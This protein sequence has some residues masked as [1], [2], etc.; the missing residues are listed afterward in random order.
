MI[1]FYFIFLN[2]GMIYFKISAFVWRTSKLY[3]IAVVIFH[4]QEL[5]K[6]SF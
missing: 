4:K 6:Y 2:F 5:K 3:L 1:L